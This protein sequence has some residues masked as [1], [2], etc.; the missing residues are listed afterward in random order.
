LVGAS[1]RIALTLLGTGALLFGAAG[2]LAWWNAWALLAALAALA[3]LTGALFWRSPGLATE[4]LTAHRRAPALDR[5]I[6]ILIGFVLPPAALVLAGLDRRLGWTTPLPL[7]LS[8]AALLPVAAGI[9][10]AAW[11]MRANSFFSSHVRIQTDR[12]H[13]VIATGPYAFVRHPGYAGATLFY[14]ALPILLG[15]LAPLPAV[16]LQVTVMAARIPLEEKVLRQGLPDY[17][18][19]CAKVPYRLIPKVW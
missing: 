9:A 6:V 12:G 15:S 17:P 7:A 3:L 5:V 4:R 13:Q 8:L 10:L 1:F 2:T 19:Y 11:A 18:A 16:L 14:L